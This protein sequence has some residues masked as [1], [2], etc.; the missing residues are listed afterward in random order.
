ISGGYTPSYFPRTGGILSQLW[1]ST[2]D[3][4]RAK[5]VLQYTLTATAND[6][7]NRVP[8]YVLPG[9]QPDM[10]DQIDGQAIILLAWDRYASQAN[11]PSFVAA[12]YPQV[13]SLM[14][15]S[16]QSPYLNSSFGLIQNLNLESFRQGSFWDTYDI[17]T[18]SFMA[19]ALREI[20]PIAQSQHDT[21]H[22][23]QWQNASSALE[24]AIAQKMKTSFDGQSVYAEM[25]QANSTSQI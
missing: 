24:N 14:D 1:L 3:I 17:L 7:L 15:A 23:T 9:G 4:P 12:T 22:A 21:V 2:G 5:A 8:H 16:L 10:T 20:I 6:G 13:A 18:Q 25:Y 11:D 19:E